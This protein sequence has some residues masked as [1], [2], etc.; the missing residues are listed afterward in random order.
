MDDDYTTEQIA[1]MI[2]HS[3]LNPG[4]TVEELEAGCAAG[5]ALQRRQRMH[6]ALLHGPLR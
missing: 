1:K 2:D 4:L 5:G 6:H 3:L